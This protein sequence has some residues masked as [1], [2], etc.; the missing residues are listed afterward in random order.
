MYFQ[1]GVQ[2]PGLHRIFCQQYRKV[3]YENVIR[4][5]ESRAP[6]LDLDYSYGQYILVL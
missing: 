4:D 3:Y 2:G 5:G 6:V 1:G